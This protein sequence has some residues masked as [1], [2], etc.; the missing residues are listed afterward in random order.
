[1][2]KYVKDEGRIITDAFGGTSYGQKP[3]P[4]PDNAY[5]RIHTTTP[6]SMSKTPSY[7]LVAENLTNT[8]GFFFGTSASFVAAEAGAHHH[9]TASSNYQTY[10]GEASLNAGD[11]LEIHPIAWSG[12]AA[13]SSKIV[14][15]YKSG[16]STGP[17]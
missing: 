7:V 11:K 1:M 15:V 6:H 5:D 17:R 8:A 3:A 13:D 10:G 12:S 9:V 2:S 4:L 14:F 16:L